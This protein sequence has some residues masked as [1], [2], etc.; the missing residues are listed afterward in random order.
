MQWQRMNGFLE[1]PPNAA[2]RDSGNSGQS[3]PQIASDSALM[4]QSE[5]P[6]VIDNAKRRDGSHEKYAADDQK[7]ASRPCLRHL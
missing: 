6:G 3:T 5:R 1:R 4:P 7:Y 2:S